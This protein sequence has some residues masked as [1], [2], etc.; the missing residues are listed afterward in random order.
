M[1]EVLQFVFGGTSLWGFT[2]YC[3]VCFL[4]MIVAAAFISFGTRLRK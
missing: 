1:V 3:G 4:L 2:R